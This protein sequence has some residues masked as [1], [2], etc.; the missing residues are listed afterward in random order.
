MMTHERILA[1]CKSNWEY[2]GIDDA[3]IREM[4]D[5][6]AAHLQDAAADGRDAE[7]VV[8][9]DVKA[10]AAAWARA[11]TPLPARLLR[12]AATLVFIT[13]CILLA[14]HL[15][16]WTTE[17]PVSTSRIAFFAVLAMVSV[18]WNMRRGSSVLGKRWLVAQLAALAAA[19]LT[20]WLAD[21]A[22]LFRMPLWGSVLL[23]VPGLPYAVADARAR[24]QRQRG[25]DR[26]EAAPAVR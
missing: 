26:D 20:V 9:T 15:F 6:L 23:L 13:G 10:F 12:V 1:V 5:E 2:R 14:G 3:S 22:V 19:L 25:K 17:L 8:G 7:T 16:R 4:L 21:D 24:R 18:P 11:R